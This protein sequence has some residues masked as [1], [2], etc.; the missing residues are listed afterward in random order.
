M[1]AALSDRASKIA[2]VFQAGF[3]D[4]ISYP[5][6]A[7]EINIR[8][9]GI[10]AVPPAGSEHAASKGIDP[11]PERRF[12]LLHEPTA[13]EIALVTATCAFLLK[14]ISIR[15]NLDY[16]ARRAGA[17]RN[18]LARAF[19]HVHGKG[20]YAWLREQR[21]VSAAK[22]LT[23]TDLSVQ[24]ISFNVG[25][26]DSGNFSTSFRQLYGVSPRSYRK[27]MRESKI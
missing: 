22:L 11:A 10:W 18:S 25:Y 17:N 20:V 27:F 9:N 4:Y 3:R 1:V 6:I 13:Q 8:I 26:E 23:T 24:E 19:K 21:M 7:A 2:A 16:F 5:F 12:S 14:D 15:R